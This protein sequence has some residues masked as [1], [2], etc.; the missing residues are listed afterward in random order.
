MRYLWGYNGR[1]DDVQRGEREMMHQ[2]VFPA[3]CAMLGRLWGMFSCRPVF[4]NTAHRHQESGRWMKESF[5]Q[6]AGWSRDRRQSIAQAILPSIGH[7]LQ[8]WAT[9]PLVFACRR[10]LCS[11]SR[12]SRDTPQSS[13]F[14]TL[15]APLPN[16]PSIAC[17]IFD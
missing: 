17:G 4:V 13:I 9:M 16:C 10:L 2:T 7:A 12:T 6:G 5:A 15:D 1:R 11:A 14:R 8:R 3:S